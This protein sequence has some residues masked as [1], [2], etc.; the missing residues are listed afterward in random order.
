[1]HVTLPDGTRLPVRPLEHADAAALRRFNEELSPESRRRFLPHAYDDATVAA[2]L[3]RAED[4]DDLVLG[5]FDGERLVGYFFLWYFRQRV[6]LLGIG[7]LDAYQSRGLGRQMMAILIDAARDAGREGVELTTM[8]DNDRA[9]ALYQKMGFR[10]IGDVE[11]EQ[12]EG[13]VVI[14]RAM[15]L[16]LVPGGRP[17]EGPHRPPV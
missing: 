5:V 11:N 8:L 17:M 12:G 15:F 2:I 6:P 4:G 14:E 3:R 10:Y 7:L 13:Q 16:E 9:F 1:M